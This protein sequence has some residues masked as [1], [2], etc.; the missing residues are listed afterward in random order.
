[1]PAPPPVQAPVIAAM[2]GT[3]HCFEHAEHAV[4][5]VLVVDRILRRLERAELV[6][7]GAG[8]KRLVAGAR[9]AS[10]P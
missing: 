2:V 9:A 8:G 7:V 5:A 3:R 4:D 6:D 10:A 1:M